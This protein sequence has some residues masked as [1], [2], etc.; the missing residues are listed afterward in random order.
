MDM[1]TG[2]IKISS[3]NKNAAQAK[4]PDQNLVIAGCGDRRIEEQL[5]RVLDVKTIG[6]DLM[7]QL[8]PNYTSAT[9]VPE[10][11]KKTLEDIIKDLKKEKST[12]K[13]SKLFGIYQDVEALLTKET[14][15]NDLLDE[16][17]MTLLQG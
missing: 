5:T 16:F 8:N 3:I 2:L 6:S 13:D 9:F 12:I 14:E 4:L 10:A 11:Y 1:D 17:R 15:N 7:Q